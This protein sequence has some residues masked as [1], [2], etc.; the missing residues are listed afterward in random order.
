[1]IIFVNLNLFRVFIASIGDEVVVIICHSRENGNLKSTIQNGFPL[2][3]KGMP[4]AVGM[5]K[6]FLRFMRQPRDLR[7]IQELITV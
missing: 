3:P 6:T 7:P 1:M 2:S 5:T 4:T